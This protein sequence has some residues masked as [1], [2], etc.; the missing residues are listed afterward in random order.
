MPTSKNYQWAVI[1]AG[2]AGIASV[3]QLIDHGV[4]SNDIIWLDPYF[5]VGDFGRLWSK[6]SSNTKV[7]IF[8]Q[9]LQTVRAFNFSKAPKDLKL[10]QLAPE[11][12]CELQ[13]VAEVLQWVTKQLLSMV[14]SEQGIVNELQLKQNHWQMTLEETTINAKQVILAVG[15]EP[16][17]LD[18]P[19][20]NIIPLATALNPPELKQATQ[21]T[22]TVAVFGASHSAI[23]ILHNLLQA[24]VKQ[25]INFYLEPLKYALPLEHFILYDNTGLKG[26]AADWARE[27]I[28][29]TL[30]DNLMRLYSNESNINQHLPECD[31]VI[32]ATG[33]KRRQKPFIPGYD[34]LN[35]DPHTG[36]IAPGLFGVG[37]AFPQVK[38]DPLGVEEARVGL[39]KFMDYLQQVMP[40]WLR[41]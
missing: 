20:A 6:V 22:D 16:T 26:F 8:L 29:G 32:Y 18:H 31:K 11:A 1:G 13:V 34:Q 12:H 10:H 30:P 28:D 39:W 37:I 5:A 7:K 27:H 24:G 19:N 25:V 17:Q 38:I 35:Y 3:G 41:Y 21:P 4:R 23:L 2:P 36:I 15:S 40:I 33:F 9:F 14:D